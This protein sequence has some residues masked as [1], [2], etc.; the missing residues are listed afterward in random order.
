MSV[1][2]GDTSGNLSGQIAGD[3]T[4][5]GTDGETN[6]LY[7]DA[8]W[9]LNKATGG[10]TPSLVETTRSMMAIISMATASS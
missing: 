8:D 3:Q 2:Y 1:Q 6:S 4:L 7:G 5:T 9:M 10:T